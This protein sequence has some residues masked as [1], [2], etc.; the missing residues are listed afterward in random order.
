[1]SVR[2][3]AARRD[4]NEALIV[5]CLQAA[6]ATVCRLSDKGVPDLLVGYQGVNMLVEVKGFKGKLTP[7]EQEWHQA[8]RGQVVI[9]RTVEEAMRLLEGI[10]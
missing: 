1:M 9:V 6:G 3:R 8:W 4:A 5:A 10:L 7:A 2:R